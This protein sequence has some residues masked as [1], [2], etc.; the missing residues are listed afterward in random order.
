MKKLFISLGT[1]ATA[2]ALVQ[3]AIAGVQI[4]PCANANSY[5]QPNSYYANRLTIFSGQSDVDYVSEFTDVLGVDW[6]QVKWFD[7]IPGQLG[8]GWRFVWIRKTSVCEWKHK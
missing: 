2:I 3:A 1:I 6:V 4:Q 5:D 8:A 7:G